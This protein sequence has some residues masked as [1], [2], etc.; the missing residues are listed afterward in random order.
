MGAKGSKSAPAVALPTPSPAP[1]LTYRGINANDPEMFPPEV[2]AEFKRTL[3]SARPDTPYV[4]GVFPHTSALMQWIYSAPSYFNNSGR[5]STILPKDHFLA[6][7]IDMCNEMSLRDVYIANV[8]E[9]ASDIVLAF[10]NT[11]EILGFV[12]L[13]RDID[14][15]HGYLICSGPRYAG[16]GSKLMQVVVTYAKQLGINCIRIG[17]SHAEEFHKKQGFVETGKQTL[18]GKEMI[19]RI[20]SGGKRKTKKNKRKTRR[21]RK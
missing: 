1:E 3:Q 7:L 5:G 18:E 8:L 13:G 21:V 12:L 2:I 16:L 9:T 19:Y 14:C 6:D 20:P 4:F 17:A 11:G 10:S 15:L